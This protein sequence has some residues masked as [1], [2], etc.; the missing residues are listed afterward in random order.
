[1]P[2]ETPGLILRRAVELL[3]DAS[4][5]KD[6]DR[7]KRSGK[8]PAVEITWEACRGT[9]GVGPPPGSRRGGRSSRRTVR[10]YSC[11]PKAA[12]YARDEPEES[13]ELKG[14]Q[15][16][17]KKGAQQEQGGTLRSLR[18]GLV[19][20]TDWDAKTPCGV[21]RFRKEILRSC[22]AVSPRSCC[23]RCMLGVRLKRES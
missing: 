19:P 4:Y 22:C 17:T 18:P 2:A 15:P 1:M 20:G 12:R 11:A 14:Q 13:E 16:G 7:D 10:P 8:L 23:M 3:V 21:V 9:D 5:W 6:G